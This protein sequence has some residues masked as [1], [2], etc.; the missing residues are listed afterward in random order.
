MKI[1]TSN[2]IER[3]F[4]LINFTAQQISRQSDW[5]NSTDKI[6]IK[7]D[8]A[9]ETF[10][11]A[12]AINFADLAQ[13][14]QSQA[15]YLQ[16]QS[17]HANKFNKLFINGK[18]FTL[19]HLDWLDIINQNY[20]KDSLI[21][22]FGHPR[23]VLKEIAIAWTVYNVLQFLF[24]FFCSAFIAYNVKALVGPNITISKT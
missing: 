23:Y 16:L 10:E 15:Q 6:K 22:I 7:V 5:T 4:T 2:E 9:A 24:G 8:D 11:V 12:Q 19:C 3:R 21:G 17:Q 20:L 14:A 1:F 13:Q 18:E